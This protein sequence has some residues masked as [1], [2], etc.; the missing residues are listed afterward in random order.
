M[1]APAILLSDVLAGPTVGRALTLDHA[2]VP[3]HMCPLTCM[4]PCAH[5]AY[6]LTCMCTYLHMVSCVKGSEGNSCN[7]RVRQTWGESSSCNPSF[8][9]S[10]QLSGR[11]GSDLEEGGWHSAQPEAPAAV[12]AHGSLCEAQT[13]RHDP[14]RNTGWCWQSC[15]GL[16]VSRR[17]GSLSKGANKWGLGREERSVVGARGDHS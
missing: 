11:L 12:W 2:A 13:H 10:S 14:V 3:E 15:L 8:F 9:I 4:H 17:P 5:A 7:W 16:C 6:A 1:P